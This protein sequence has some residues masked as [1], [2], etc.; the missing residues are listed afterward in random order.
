[1]N[2]QGWKKVIAGLGFA[3]VV[4]VPTLSVAA[5][6]DYGHGHGHGGK[7]HRMEQRFER[8][9][10]QLSLTEG[11]IAQIRANHEA[12]RAE[13]T[14]LRQREHALREQVRAAMDEGADQAALDSFASALGSLEIQKMQQRDKSRQQFLAVLTD[15]QKTEL[16]AMKQ[17]HRE[18]REQHLKDRQERRQARE[19]QQLD[20]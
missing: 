10:E 16:E 2:H 5:G 14:A 8:L 17:K 15:E 12:G 9:A 18:M 3:A 7:G 1:M 4:A 19:A 6:Y 13:H 20:S 11:Q